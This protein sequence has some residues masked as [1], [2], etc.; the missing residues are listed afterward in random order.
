MEWFGIFQFFSS[1]NAAIIF[2]SPSQALPAPTVA[3][4]DLNQQ[5]TGGTGSVY[6]RIT[7][8]NLAQI[9]VVSSLA[10]TTVRGRTYGWVDNVGRNA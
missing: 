3:N 5:V 1:T 10:S 2:G 8:N 7:T 6:A 9:A 4:G